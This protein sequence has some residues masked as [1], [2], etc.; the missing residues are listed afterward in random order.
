M[1]TSSPV[2]FKVL[3]VMIEEQFNREKKIA[4]LCLIYSILMFRRCR[5][6]SRLQRVNS[7]LLVESDV[8]MEVNT[9][10]NIKRCISHLF[11]CTS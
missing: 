2:T 1:K 3:S 8:N 11:N 4:P 10:I 6:L 9:N 5:E 7:I